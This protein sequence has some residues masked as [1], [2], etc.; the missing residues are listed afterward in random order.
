MRISQIEWKKYRIPLIEPFKI[1]FAVV[2]FAEGVFLRVTT[3]NGLV[4]YGEAAP[5]C[6]VTGETPDTVV[7]ILEFLKPL[8]LGKDPFDLEE[9][10]AM[11]EHYVYGNPAAKCAV[12][13]AMYDL[14]GKAS[15]VPVYKLLGGYRNTI[16]SDMT[17]GMNTTEKMA[18]EAEKYVRELGYTVLKLKVG[19]DPD[20][21]IEVLQRIRER[22]GPDV[23]LRVDANQGYDVISAMYAIEGF[24]RAG[25]E[26]IEQCL[27]W[28][29]LD[30]AALLRQKVTGIKLML[31]ESV[32]SPVDAARLVKQGCADILNIK[33][34]KSGGLLPAL[35]ISD[36]AEASGVTCMVGSM[37]ETKLSI[38]AAVSLVAAR[39]NIVEADCD[40]HMCLKTNGGVTGG[41]DQ[42]GGLYTLPDKP[43][44]GVEV[45][46]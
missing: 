24:K 21:D 14:C 4:G 7:A 3:D 46:F 43:G 40:G 38:T 5:F 29:D 27:P 11:M 6:P 36:I 22:V 16:I 39:K 28:W 13:L 2:E 35:K 9:I 25:V 23:H 20:G 41:F 34:M 37:S 10:H 33:L 8:L 19:I 17:I 44:F 45:D 30:G 18:D 26:S 32:H 31:D 1:S 42:K 12:D 15:G